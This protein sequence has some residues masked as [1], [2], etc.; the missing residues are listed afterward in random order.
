MTEYDVIKYVR[1]CGQD[2]ER[3]IRLA[4]NIIQARLKANGDITKIT[5]ATPLTQNLYLIHLKIETP[6]P[7]SALALLLKGTAWI[8]LPETP[9][10]CVE[11]QATTPIVEAKRN[12]Q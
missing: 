8:E 9:S 7:P 6:L 4:R 5:S 1:G 11:R 2:V 3:A 12:K 10:K